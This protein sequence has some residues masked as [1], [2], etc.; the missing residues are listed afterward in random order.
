MD[1]PTCT[2]KKDLAFREMRHRIPLDGSNAIEV[3]LTSTERNWYRPVMYYMA[4]MDCENNL[5]TTI[6]DH[7]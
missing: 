3:Y 4:V 5:H 1:K 6:G 2:E 7:L